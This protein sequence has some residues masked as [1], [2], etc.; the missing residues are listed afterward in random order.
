MTYC[1]GLAPYAYH[2]RRPQRRYGGALPLPLPRP[3][4]SCARRRHGV[5]S[6][7]PHSHG[8]EGTPDADGPAARAEMRLCN[9]HAWWKSEPSRPNAGSAAACVH[10]ARPASR[11]PWTGHTR[12]CYPHAGGR[13]VCASIALT[14]AAGAAT[15]RSGRSKTLP[16]TRVLGV[17][18]TRERTQNFGMYLSF[19]TAALFWCCMTML[20]ELRI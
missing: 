17:D 2:G 10:R 7:A 12:R 15:A 1:R 13:A 14:P 6:A 4:Q 3:E 16:L 20:H 5:H 11:G 18:S 19:C 9:L 8:M